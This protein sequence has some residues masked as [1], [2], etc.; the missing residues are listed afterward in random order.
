MNYAG[1]KQY[2]NALD[3]YNKSLTIEK[4]IDEK[5]NSVAITLNWIGIIYKNKNDFSKALQ[6]YEESLSISKQIFGEKHVEL[7]YA[8]NNIAIILYNQKRYE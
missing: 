2:D 7:S 6:L 4:S 1:L 8:L 3:H 5:S